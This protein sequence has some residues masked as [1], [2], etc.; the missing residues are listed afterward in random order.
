MHFDMI[1]VHCE[2]FKQLFVVLGIIQKLYIIVVVESSIV[3][4]HVCAACIGIV[5]KDR[6]DYM[7]G[8]VAWGRR[9]THGCI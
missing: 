5:G 3:T 2:N 9:Q 1:E 4:V 6:S 8:G 7:L